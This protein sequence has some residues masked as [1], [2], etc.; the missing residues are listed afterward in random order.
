MV[1]IQHTTVRS[2]KPVFPKE[3][4][5]EFFTKIFQPADFISICL[6]LFMGLIYLWQWAGNPR[7]K[8]RG[9]QEGGEVD[10]KSGTIS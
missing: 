9:L 3:F 4:T 6:V 1:A 2:T 5:V 10:E 7:R 8:N